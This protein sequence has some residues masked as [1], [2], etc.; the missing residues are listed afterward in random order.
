MP[1]GE[2]EYA[3]AAKWYH[4][5]SDGDGVLRRGPTQAEIE[6][7]QR[8]IPGV[9][10]H[11]VVREGQRLSDLPA[12]DSYSYELAQVFVAAGDIAEMEEKYNRAAGELTFEIDD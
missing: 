3:V 8:N 2:G 5:R 11:P 7:I 10:I 9:I 4:R 6:A 1:R 12:Q